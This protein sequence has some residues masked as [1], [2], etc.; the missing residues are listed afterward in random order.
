MNFGL[1][2]RVPGNLLA[3]LR[4]SLLFWLALVA[5][6]LMAA[7]LME[8]WAVAVQ[9][10]GKYLSA[11]YKYLA[12]SEA[13]NQTRAQLLPNLSYQFEERYTDQDILRADNSIY[14]PG[15]SDYST[16]TNGL[17]LTQTIFDYTRWKRYSQSKITVNRAEVEFNLAK[18]ELLVRLAEAYFLILERGDQLNTVQIEKKA[19][20][21]HLMLAEGKLRSGLGNRVD[22]ED[23][24]SRALNAEAK[25][26]ELKSRMADSEYA[27]REVIGTLPTQLMPLRPNIALEKPA[28][29]SSAEWIKL[30]SQYNLQLRAKTL[31]LDAA[32]EE[33]DVVQGGHY[34]TLE[35]VVNA[36][37]TDTDGSVYGG[38]S[39][40]ETADIALKVNFPLYRGGGVSSEVRQATQNRYS[41]LEELNDKRRVVE[42]EAQDAFNRIHTAIVQIDALE[43]SVNA[44]QRLLQ[45]RDSGYRTGK[46]S[47][48]TVLDAQ[49]DLSRVQQALTKARYDYVLNTLRLKFT[50]GDL[51]EGDLALVNSW[52]Q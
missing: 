18:Q 47:M 5:Q 13:I 19:M 16:S 39:E 25:E 27:L 35:L 3:R 51:Q 21:R 15:T 29:D 14:D 34:P 41:V 45:A 40:I 7:D 2:S 37:N 11:Q 26:F 30:A 9:T 4:L 8:L 46:N 12:N 50:V 24:R 20:N 23:A 52:L 44:Q 48:L 17:A 36:V 32:Q 43:Q 38:G 31:E 22:V 10:D 49:N 33:I 6:P 1:F 28:P 42:R